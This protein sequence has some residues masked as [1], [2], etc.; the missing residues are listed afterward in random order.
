MRTIV[1]VAVNENATAVDQT[2]SAIVK[3]VNVRQDVIIAR[4]LN[5]SKRGP[6]NHRN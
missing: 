2:T 3:L 1:S 4:K 5:R 6:L